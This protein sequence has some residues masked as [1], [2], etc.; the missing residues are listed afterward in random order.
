MKEY[1]IDIAEFMYQQK[2][3]FEMR[4]LSKEKDIYDYFVTKEKNRKIYEGIVDS[5]IR[6]FEELLNNMSKSVITTLEELRSSII[7]QL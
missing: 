1:I 6:K 4:G 5:E 7:K 2:L 3:S